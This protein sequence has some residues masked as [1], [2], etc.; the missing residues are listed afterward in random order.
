MKVNAVFQGGGV[1]G[2]GFVGA[3]YRMEREGVEWAQLAGTSAGAIIASL[4]AVG[5]SGAELKKI[6]TEVNYSKLL[7]RDAFQSVPILGKGL[8]VILERGYHKTDY[9]EKW[10]TNL[11][12]AKGKTKFKDLCVNNKSRLKIIASDVTRKK[13]IMFPDGLVDYGIDPSE[14]EIAKAVGMSICI[15]IFFSP[16]VLEYRNDSSYVVDGGIYSN[17]PIWVFDKEDTDKL[18]TFGFKFDNDKNKLKSKYNPFVYY[19]DLFESIIDTVDEEYIEN[20]NSI[21]ILT[22]PALEV[23]ST[24]FN[25]TSSETQKLYLSGYNTA[26]NF[27]NSMEYKKIRR[28]LIV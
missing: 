5:Y 10:L 23:K 6:M 11:Y 27:L 26:N 4:L 28:N 2:I 1:K 13:M 22:I 7:C 17:F 9:I 12:K 8:G 24:N 20:K 3:I 14:F 15:P 16:K 19:M 21:K 18:P 25:I